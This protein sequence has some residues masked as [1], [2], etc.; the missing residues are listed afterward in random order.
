MYRPAEACRIAEVAPYV[1]RYWETEF[2]AL[3]EGKDKGTTKLYTSRDVKII[4]RIRELLYDEGFT[5]AGA[6]KRLEAEIAEGR[7]D[8]DLAPAPPVEEQRHSEKSAPAPRRVEAPPPPRKAAATPVPS[9]A[10]RAA[11]T[12]KVDAPHKAASTTAS[13][14]P[15]FD[16]RTVLRELKDIVRLLDRPRK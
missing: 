12:A 7:F 10:P 15:D 8:D 11:V 14:S 1:L 13:A 4:A 16:R 6:K 9:V 2:P 5:V 3:S